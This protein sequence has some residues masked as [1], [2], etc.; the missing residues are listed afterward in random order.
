MKLFTFL[1]SFCLY[2]E[3]ACELTCV[4]TRL[5]IFG[6]KSFV[7]RFVLNFDKDI[8]GIVGPNG[9][10]KSNIVDSLRWILGETHAKQLRGGS[11][12]DLI[13]NGSDSRRPLGMAEVSITIR[14]NRAWAEG[15]SAGQGFEQAQSNSDDL[16]ASNA[17]AEHEILQSNLQSIPGLFDA[18]EIQ[19]TRRL[20][21]SGESE[22][23]INRIPCRLRD[24]TE[25][26]RLIGLGARGLNIVQQGQIGEFISKKPI[27]RRAL[28]EEAAGIS[29]FRARM[30]A[31][32]RKLDRTSDNMARL[33]DI[34]LEVEKQVRIL[35]RQANRARNR[36]EL[37]LNLAEAEQNLFALRAAQILKKRQS[38]LADSSEVTRYLEEKQSKLERLEARQEEAKSRLTE[39][40]VELVALRRKRDELFELFNSEREREHELRVELARLEGRE[41]AAEDEYQRI[42]D[43]ASSLEAELLE[44]Q[45]I[46]DSKK[47]ILD[48]TEADARRL[49]ETQRL[50]EEHAS[51]LS[52]VELQ[53]EA[54][55]LERNSLKNQLDAQI[56]SRDVKQIVGADAELILLDQL[57]SALRYSSEF[58]AAILVAL[59]DFAEHYLCLDSNKFAELCKEHGHEFDKKFGVIDVQGVPSAA[60]SALSEEEQELAPSAKRLSD[61]VGISEDRFADSLNAV[62][63]NIYFVESLEEGLA[64]N[65]H[66]SSRGRAGRR[67]VTRAG[68][69][70]Y[71][72]GWSS[73]SSKDFSVMARNRLSE[74]KAEILD[75]EEQRAKLVREHEDVVRLQEAA[76]RLLISS[77]SIELSDS[78]VSDSK[79]SIS[80]VLFKVAEY[81]NAFQF[82]ASRVKRLLS[83]QEALEKQIDVVSK[84]RQT[85]MNEK[86][87]L[88][89]KL[90]GEET[91]ARAEETRSAEQE[92][93]VLE[94]KISRTEEDR[95]RAQSELGAIADEVASLRRK[96]EGL[97]KRRK[98]QALGCREIGSGAVNAS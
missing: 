88:L 95:G 35:K 37:K 87:Q 26:Y 51:K 2:F 15:L 17:P 62:L 32:Q 50:L 82:D 89:L 20:Y 98:Q 90:D 92:F 31:A 67:F 48:A 9:C 52:K 40:D 86:K 61:L 59:G 22:Y 41:K 64:V 91:T 10:G 74:L 46:L 3:I 7:E 66:N 25:I 54:C 16:T 72:W 33:S 77:L 63:E 84:E 34:I 76:S 24:M 8:I 57:A 96:L 1:L 97:K 47:E 5:E 93:A 44:S 43:R 18:A 73:G 70:I 78:G 39:V 11:L 58:E 65:S 23:F 45:A 27:E 38:L 75:L 71:P 79:R 19:L 68:E 29:G 6:F 80:E 36:N 42:S 81:K 83:E 28:L 30:E 13:F 85:C 14:P 21:R 69:L 49:E 12:E 53:A 94:D 56:E 4:V 60:D 55:R